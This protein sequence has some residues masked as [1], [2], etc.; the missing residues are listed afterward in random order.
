MKLKWKVQPTPTGRYHSFNRRGWPEA[1]L[2]DQLIAAFE[3]VDD[4]YPPSVKAGHHQE[5]KVRIYNYT[6]GP[7][8]RST[9][10]LKQR[11]KTLEEGK[12]LVA[13]FFEKY[14]AWLP[15]EVS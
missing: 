14:L 11:A 2:H 10:Y 7:Q 9:H 4:Y 3:C 8:K 5:L 1:F 13:A 6:E 12:L 15:K